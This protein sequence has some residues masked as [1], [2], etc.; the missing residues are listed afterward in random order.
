M[1]QDGLLI[2]TL[3]NI[4]MDTCAGEMAKSQ[5]E[6]QRKDH[7]RINSDIMLFLDDAKIREC[8]ER[9]L[10]KL[11]DVSSAR[12]MK[13]GWYGVHSNVKCYTPGKRATQHSTHLLEV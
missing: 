10:Q 9:T 12:A 5:T 13:Y 11:L 3:Y 7:D 4:Y 2:P 6:A 8:T 1:S